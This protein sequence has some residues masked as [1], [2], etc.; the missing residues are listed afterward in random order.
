M[1]MHGTDPSGDPSRQPESPW[2][3][4]LGPVLLILSAVLGIA[5]L[6]FIGFGLFAVLSFSASLDRGNRFAPFLFAVPLVSGAL[7]AGWI[8]WRWHFKPSRFAASARRLWAKAGQED[9]A[10]WTRL[11]KA[12]QMGTEDLVRDEAAARFWL[13]KAA[14]AG[15]PEAMLALATLLRGGA[16]GPRNPARAA[17]LESAAGVRTDRSDTP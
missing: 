13:E 11:G 4:R 15:D 1:N 9:A 17:A 14:R 3:R 10:A 7:L 16:G 2:I 12:Y 5:A 6:G 8:S